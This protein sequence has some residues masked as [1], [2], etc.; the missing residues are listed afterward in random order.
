MTR[1]LINLAELF[2]L[3]ENANVQIAYP[4]WNSLIPICCFENLTTQYPVN[5]DDSTITS[6]CT[7]SSVSVTSFY[8][9]SKSQN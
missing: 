6:R 9:I 2:F 1:F 4:N 5:P 3:I 7:E 8:K